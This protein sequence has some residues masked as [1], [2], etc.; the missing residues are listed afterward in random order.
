MQD[1]SRWLLAG[2]GGGAGA[3]PPTRGWS[4]THRGPAHQVN[5]QIFRPHVSIQGAEGQNHHMAHDKKN[6]KTLCLLAYSLAM[7]VVMGGNTKLSP[8]T[9]RNFHNDFLEIALHKPLPRTFLGDFQPYETRNI[10]IDFEKLKQKS[11]KTAR[12]IL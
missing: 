11:N 8:A 9:S 12:S 1:G 2:D 7:L 3:G 5:I 4:L 6:L 10:L